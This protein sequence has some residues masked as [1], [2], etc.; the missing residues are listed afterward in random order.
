MINAELTARAARFVQE[1]LASGNA[2][3][4]AIKAGFS[5]KGASVAGN[6]MLR[7]AM[8]QNALQARQAKDAA[9]LSISRDRVL[10]GLLEGVAQAREQKN[11]MATIRGWAEI[12]RLLGYYSPDRVKVDVNVGAGV[13]IDRMNRL[14]D[15][16]LM[17]IIEEVQ[18][19][20]P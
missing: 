11:A 12:G 9:R 16:E 3:A 10:A 14:S 20:S 17:K 19:T 5:P 2:T 6:R 1:F 18:P 13:E 7:N 8:V 15:A 4:G